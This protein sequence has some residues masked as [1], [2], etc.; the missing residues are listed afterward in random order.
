MMK[1]MPQ[2]VSG[3]SV[4]SQDT[5][6]EADTTVSGYSVSSQDT[7]TEADATDSFWLQC[8]QS[9]YTIKMMPQTM[10]LCRLEDVPQVEF[11]YLVLPGESYRRRLLSLIHI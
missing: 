6:T 8:Q 5:H 1:M 3:Y 10:Y 7:H 4:S 2:T 11:M 9:G